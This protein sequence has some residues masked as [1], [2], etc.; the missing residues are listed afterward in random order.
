VAARQVVAEEEPDRVGAAPERREEDRAVVGEQLRL[1]LGRREM[2][3]DIRVSRP[4]TA[5]RRLCS[6][7]H[8]VEPKR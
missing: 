7:G 1:R 3:H 8:A 4:E 2:P 5:D 6:A